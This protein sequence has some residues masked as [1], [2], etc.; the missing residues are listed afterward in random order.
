MLGAAGA[1]IIVLLVLAIALVNREDASR[2]GDD[3]QV[4]IIAEG[5]LSAAAAVE[6][7]ASQVLL[8]VTVADAGDVAANDIVPTSLTVLERTMNELDRRFEVFVVEIAS[9]E[10]ATAIEA[11]TTF[12]SATSALVAAAAP[13][14]LDAAT[15]AAAEHTL[16]YGYLVG[17]FAAIRDE[18]VQEVLLAGQD[19]GRVADAVRFLIFFLLPLLL[20]IAYRR[21]AKRREGRLRL[22]Q[23]LEHQRSLV[24]LRDEFIADLSHELRT[25]LTG[26]YGF[27]LALQEIS[28]LNEEEH[29]L[30]TMIVGESVEMNRMV[31]DLI[32]AGRS[33]AGTLSVDC[34]EVDLGPLISSTVAPFVDRGMFVTVDADN[35]AVR[36]DRTALRH[37]LVNLLSN[38]ARHGGDHTVVTTFQDEDEVVVQVIDDGPGVG[39]EILPMLFGRYLHGRGGAL[40]RGSVGLGTAVANAYAEALG[41]TIEY[42]REDDR[43]VFEVRLPTIAEEPVEAPASVLV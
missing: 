25:P 21:S 40:V 33:A 34:V 39:E 6:N 41:G 7:A 43:T 28:E 2:A 9:D 27:A 35:V 8:A 32:A 15:I 26:I 1:A 18:H 3:A 11:I 30:V 16:A 5:T 42:L 24:L 20:I 17:A 13:T 36:G 10:Q 19:L 22:E 14:D 4:A 29:D 37:I 38:A 12:S 31:D 23:E